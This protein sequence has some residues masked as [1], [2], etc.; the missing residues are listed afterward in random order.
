MLFDANDMMNL[1]ILNDLMSN[2]NACMQQ[3]QAKQ[4]KKLALIFSMS[5]NIKTIS[6]TIMLL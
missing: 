6:L 1:I 4:Q 5:N 3:V 2:T